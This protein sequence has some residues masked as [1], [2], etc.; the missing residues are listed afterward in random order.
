MREIDFEEK[1]RQYIELVEQEQ[2]PPEISM[3][4]Y[5]PPTYHHTKDY[6]AKFPQTINE[7]ESVVFKR[8]G[9]N[10]LVA[11]VIMIVAGISLYLIAGKNFGFTQLILLTTLL[12]VVLPFLLDNKPVIIITRQGIWVS[13]EDT[14][15]PWKDI[16]FIFIKEVHQ[17]HTEY[18]LIVHYYD[19]EK[20]S[21]HKRETALAGIVSPAM[22]ASAIEAFR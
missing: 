5:P 1:K 22:L 19:E 4:Q 14:N 12:L 6:A 18:F 2:I 10:L 15:I 21:F 3:W 7:T 17:E 16:L 8:P 9:N 20:G 13:K 11:F